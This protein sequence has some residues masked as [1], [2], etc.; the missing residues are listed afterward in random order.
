MN[1]SP[2]RPKDPMSKHWCFT[3]NNYTMEEYNT[4]SLCEKEYLVMGKEMSAPRDPTD[5][6]TATPHLQGYIVFVNRKRL[7]GVKK[8]S[9]RSHWEIKRGTPLE[10]ATYCKK[11]GNFLEQGVLP[12]TGPEA[13]GK[14]TH[15]KWLQAY[16]AAK[17]NALDLIE[18]KMLI[19]NYSSFKRIAQDNQFVPPDLT[20]GVKHEWY[21]G[22]PR[23][24]KSRAARQNFPNAYDKPCNK[25]WDGYKNH[26]FVIIDDFDK[27]HKCLGHHLKRWADIYSFPAEHKGHTFQIRPKTVVVTSNYHPS[28]IFDD[29][30]ILLAAILSRFNLVEFTH[31]PYNVWAPQKERPTLKRTHAGFFKEI[32]PDVTQALNDRLSKGL[33]N[34]FSQPI[35]LTQSYNSSSD[36]EDSSDADETSSSASSGDMVCT[37]KCDVI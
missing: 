15:D 17:R 20:P 37:Q 30:P 7:A 1:A 2:P 33:P 23:T 12:E 5:A 3:L 29:D 18:P 31:N 13:G 6:N 21:W 24:G 8:L 34:P 4:F 19:Q 36:A 22:A 35:D 28:E 32:D 10:A 16:E 25:W 14:A 9:P 26:E 11:D 27:S